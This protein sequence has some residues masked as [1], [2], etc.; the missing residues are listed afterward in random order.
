M[1]DLHV[2]LRNHWAAAHGGVDLAQRVA[3]RHRD[4]E[5][6]PGLA[7]LAEEF[8]E[9]RASLRDI[10]ATVGAR[11]GL[12]LPALAR[13]G[14]RVGRFKPNGHL[15]TR[16]PVSDVLELEALRGTLTIKA[17]GWETL[18]ALAEQDD[19]LPTGELGSLAARARA[20]GRAL[21]QIHHQVATGGRWTR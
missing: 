13:V 21:A 18:L 8:S 4:G 7:V 1:S 9:D 20:Q 5:V 6:G 14:E 10:M 12:V 11:P 16:S 15:V 17:S 2:H 3:R 19:R